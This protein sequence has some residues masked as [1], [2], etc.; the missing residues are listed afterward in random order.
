MLRS[1]TR[2]ALIRLGYDIRRVSSP[3]KVHFPDQSDPI[4]I[5]YQPA[6]RGRAVFEIALAETRSFQA[7]A[8]PL[9]RDRHPFVKALEACRGEAD[10]QA[11]RTVIEDTLRTY[12]EQVQPGSAV[13]AL[14]V[15]DDEAPGLRGMPASV[16]LLPWSGQTIDQESDRFRRIAKHEGL[17]NG[18][19]VSLSD[20]LTTFGPVTRAKLS[21]EVGR[22][23]GLVTSTTARGFTRLAPRSPLE[24]AA[25]R[26]GNQYKWLINT[27]QHRFATAA[28]LAIKS[29]PA[30]V[31]QVIRREDAPYWPQVVSGV[32]TEAGALS[33]FDR[34]FSGTPAPV[35]TGWIE[36][37][38]GNERR[39]CL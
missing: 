36:R 4:T 35:C 29:L 26:S 25:I 22:L 7:L 5:E 31:T 14:G 6:M 9:R 1:L 33:V 18:A 39:E 8:L 32:F 28:A 37:A 19:V 13:E 34:I 20:G 2:M 21:L 24:V 10:A 23:S 3:G 15:T 11:A 30:V 16:Y 12:Y 38:A 27:G 17:E